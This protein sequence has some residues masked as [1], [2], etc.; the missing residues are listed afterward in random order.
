M[1]TKLHKFATLLERQGIEYEI[2]LDLIEL[3]GFRVVHRNDKFKMQ[4]IDEQTVGFYYGHH[5]ISATHKTDD[6]K[7]IFHFGEPTEY[8]TVQLPH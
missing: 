8:D 7:V 6:K 2:A 1:T 5:T 3:A 4:I